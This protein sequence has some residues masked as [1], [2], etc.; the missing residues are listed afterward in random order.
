MKRTPAAILMT[1]ALCAAAAA[2]SKASAPES[3]RAKHTPSVGGSKSAADVDEVERL[4]D[5]WELAQGG[6]ALNNIRTRVVRG[7]ITMSDS[8]LNGTFE[9]YL[10]IPRKV[11]MVANTPRGQLIEASDGDR[12][13]LQTPWGG[14]MSAGD[15]EEALARA[16]SG[17]GGAKWREYFSAASVKGRAFLD[18]REVIVLAVTPRGRAP[19]LWHFDARTGLLRKIAFVNPVAGKGGERLLGVYYDSYATV[20][21]V[22]VPALFRQVYTNFTLTFM[23]TETRHNVFIADAL[24]RDPN[25]R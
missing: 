4:L 19:M 9:K 12:R 1:L 10:K 13:W 8:N 23:V 6:A 14:A 21:G 20:D 7:H 11:M 25:A 5:L 18:G 2:Q 22:K 15:G 17:R 3:P 16:T 24:F